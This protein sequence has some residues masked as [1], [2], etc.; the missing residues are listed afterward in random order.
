MKKLCIG[1]T[2]CVLLFKVNTVHAQYTWNSDSLFK[3]GK[4]NSGRIW[5]YA[6]GDYYYKGHADSLKRGGSNQYTGIPEN[7]N[8]FQFRRI[9][10]GYDYN[11]TQKF[12]AELLLAAEDNFPAGNPPSSTSASGDELINNK[13]SFYIKLANVRVKNIWKGTDLV[14]GQMSTPTFALL[15]ERVWSYRSIERTITD[16]RRTPSY[17]LGAALQGVFDPSTK[18]FGYNAMVG[19][20]SSAKPEADQFKWFYG[21]VYG[22]F[23]DKKLVIDAYADYERLNWT[24]TWHHSR[25]MLKGYIAYNSA[26]TEKGMDPGKG[27][28]IG[29]EGFINNLKN[30]NLATRIS[31]GSV[32][33]ASTKASGLSVYVHGDIVPTKL[34]F[35]ARVDLYKPM[36]NIDNAVYNKYVGN[37]GNYNDNSYTTSGAAVTPTGDETYKQTFVTAGLD[38]MPAKNVHFMPNIWYERYATQLATA[39]TDHDLVYRVTF[40]YVFGK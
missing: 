40:Y 1:F 12:S 22:Y 16:I 10:L 33:T 20:G 21:D 2:L 28:T 31:D 23:F 37:T 39:N 11:I 4:P 15:S 26:A 29:V 8:A 13:L 27:Y 18:N 6:F 30:D 35:F 32:D 25:E 19:N 17:D 24:S 14:V 3:A 7:R 36:N 38:F 9:Y 34:R 5:G